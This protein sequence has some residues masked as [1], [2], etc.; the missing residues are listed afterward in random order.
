MRASANVIRLLSSVMSLFLAMSR[1][2][3]PLLKA[4][5]LANTS[6]PV[7]V[8]EFFGISRCDKVVLMPKNLDS[9]M[10][11]SFEII[12]LPRASSY[13]FLFSFK[14]S[15]RSLRPSSLI[16]FPLRFKNLIV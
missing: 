5:A 9:I 15:T 12:L 4:R 10:I 3:K 13:K 6:K 7:S 14:K 2:F 11:P 16:L 8:N 1:N